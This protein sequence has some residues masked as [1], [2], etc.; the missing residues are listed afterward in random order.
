MP[1]MIRTLSRL[2]PCAVLALALAGCVGSARD[3]AQTIRFCHW[4]DAH[5]TEVTASLLDQFQ[6]L[7]PTLRVEDNRLG[8]GGPTYH[9]KLMNLLIGDKTPDVIM[10]ESYY[11]S[12]LNDLG[13]FADLG[14]YLSKSRLIKEQDFY[15][16]IMEEFQAKGKTFGIPRDIA[17]LAC[18]YYNK[19]AFDE[20]RLPYPGL[21]L[22][23]PQPFASMAAKLMKRDSSGKV[24]RW[25]YVDDWDIIDTFAYSAASFS[26]RENLDPQRLA[27]L[28]RQ[29]A[30]RGIQFRADLMFRYK[31][32]PGPSDR[33]ELNGSGGGEFFRLGRAAMFYSGSWKIPE[34]RQIKDFD[35]DMTLM[36]AYAKNGKR[37]WDR[38]GSGYALNAKAS[39]ARAANAWK[40]I[41]F[42]GGPEAQ[43]AFSAAGVIQPANI[44]VA[45]GPS[46]LDGHKPAHKRVL[47]E[48]IK[49]I[50]AGMPMGAWPALRED[51]VEQ[52]LDLVWL[53]K[54]RASEALAGRPINGKP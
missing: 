27:E 15:P 18:L 22:R 1:A 6:K 9:D 40:L 8:A 3:D 48:A 47:L 16:E 12:Q 25:G 46:F 7:N 23:W 13:F 44:K 35:W 20:A 49:H 11:S 30:I 37:A 54:L 50:Y 2:M 45:Q 31:V 53:G 29:A 28:E 38:G 21:G 24:V 17:P 19:N 14:P 43:A 5:E 33:E 26:G 51:G 41:E 42:M 4:G 34:F 10:M 52:K 39:P 36:P 32:L